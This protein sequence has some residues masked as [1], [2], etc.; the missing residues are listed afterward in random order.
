M[1]SVL[2]KV[3]HKVAKAEFESFFLFLV[4]SI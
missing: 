4:G 1:V 2:M 3:R